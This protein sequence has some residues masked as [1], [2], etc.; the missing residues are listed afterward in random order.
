MKSCTLYYKPKRGALSSRKTQHAWAEFTHEVHCKVR[1][2]FQ[3]DY[4]AA[5]A[6]I[7]RRLAVPLSLH[8]HPVKLVVSKSP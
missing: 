2:E 7:A 8:S 4:E 6:E 1:S 3:A 5:I